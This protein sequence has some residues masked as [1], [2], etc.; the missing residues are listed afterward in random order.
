MVVSSEV[1]TSD[2]MVCGSQGSTG[3]GGTLARFGTEPRNWLQWEVVTHPSLGSEVTKTCGLGR[4]LAWI[5]EKCT[6]SCLPTGA[7]WLGRG[8]GTIRA[9]DLTTQEGRLAS[10]P[11]KNPFPKESMQ[12]LSPAQSH[13]AMSLFLRGVA[14]HLLTTDFGARK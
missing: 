5:Q 4:S 7:L 13:S 3:V 12:V 6:I 9:V 8:E 2:G 10:W 11:A 14:G 1:D